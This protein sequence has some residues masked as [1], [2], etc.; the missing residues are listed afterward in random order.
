MFSKS[1]YNEN[2]KELIKANK[3][4]K[5][6]VGIIKENLDIQ[7]DAKS[8]IKKNEKEI[9]VLTSQNETKQTLKTQTSLHNFK[10]Y[11]SIRKELKDIKKQLKKMNNEVKE[12]NRM[13]EEA[14]LENSEIEKEIE[15]QYKI[16][17]ENEIYSKAFYKIDKNLIEIPEES[18]IA[19]VKHIEQYNNSIYSFENNSKLPKP[20]A[21]DFL[22]ILNALRECEEKQKTITNKTIASEKKI[23][24]RKKVTKTDAKPEEKKQTTKKSSTKNKKTENKKTENNK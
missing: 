2:L 4:D 15:D 3:A 11:I 9:K 1:G 8:V 10:E 18:Y 5:S 12:C 14:E 23:T 20:K 13:K 22:G 16:F 19:Y 24:T 7:A 17:K 21:E 6:I